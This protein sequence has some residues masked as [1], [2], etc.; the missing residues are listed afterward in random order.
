MKQTEHA[1]GLK[2]LT[3]AEYPSK[4]FG[5]RN[6]VWSGFKDSG[7]LQIIDNAIVNKDIGK[8]FLHATCL[9]TYITV[10][11]CLKQ[12]TYLS[13]LCVYMP[14]QEFCLDLKVPINVGPVLNV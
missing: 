9:L 14:H 12:N 5:V 6:F 3:Y 10:I 8:L 13:I 1:Y 4:K 7:M 2:T 11:P